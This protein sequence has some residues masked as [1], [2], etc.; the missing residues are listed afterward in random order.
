MSSRKVVDIL[1]LKKRESLVIQRSIEF[2]NLIGLEV[3]L[4]NLLD[5]P[6]LV[7]GDYWAFVTYVYTYVYSNRFN[8]L[9]KERSN[10]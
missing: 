10:D 4:R 1:E 7:M 5:E 8:E 9:L 3:T 6:M 2:E